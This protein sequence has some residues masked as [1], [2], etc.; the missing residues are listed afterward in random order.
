VLVLVRGPA[1]AT[2]SSGAAKRGDDGEDKVRSHI[3]CNLYNAPNHNLADIDRYVLDA[4]E[5]G[6]SSHYGSIRGR[7]LE[8]DCSKRGAYD[9]RLDSNQPS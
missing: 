4:G 2:S 8:E 7:R 1:E 6:M 9:H 5:A 3:E